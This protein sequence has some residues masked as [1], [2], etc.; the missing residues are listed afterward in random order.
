VNRFF[1]LSLWSAQKL[2]RL[3]RFLLLVIL[4]AAAAG[5]ALYISTLHTWHTTRLTQE[6]TAKGKIQT[7]KGYLKQEKALFTELNTTIYSKLPASEQSIINRYTRDSL[8][9][10][11]RWK[12]NYNRTL[13][14]PSQDAKAG[15]LLLHGMSDSP[16]SLHTLAHTLHAKGAYVIALRLPGHGTIPSGLTT[17]RWQDMAKAVRLAM[18]YLH[19]Q[20]PNKPLY[21]VGYS[22]GAPLALHYT[23]DA[24]HA[25]ALKRPDKLVFISP[26]IGVSKAAP[27]AVWQSRI[28]HLLHLPK[29]EW[30]DIGPEYDPFKYTSF[31]VNAGDQV[32]RLAKEVQTQ[33]DRYETEGNKNTLPSILS[34][35][36]VIDKT[37]S[38]DDTINNLYRRLPEGNNTLVLFDINHN[39][40]RGMLINPSILQTAQQR[41]HATGAHYNL[42]VLSN[43]HTHTRQIELIR[44]GKPIK[45]LPYFWEKELYS[46]SHVS[47]PFSAKDPLYGNGS[48]Q[49]PSISLGHLSAY[50][51]SG[52]LAIPPSALLRLRYNPFYNYM[53]QQIVDFLKQ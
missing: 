19:A 44:N 4:V 23:F 11:A 36:S 51:E 26:A 32:Y 27:F 48:S 16:Y 33:F 49:S 34:F 2:L 30:N 46:L 22:T 43:I 3:I 52:V 20:L 13:V 28:G 47:L 6:F 10:P 42:D 7:F 31:A 24:M 50:G 29:M 21:I 53:Q 39:F 15:I 12:P 35:Q 38:V 9:D 18:R 40:S 17:V 1:H 8:S 37:V 41:T 5:L 45:K 14:L 25:S